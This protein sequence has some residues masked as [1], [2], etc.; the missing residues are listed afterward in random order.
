MWQVAG[1]AVQSR[2]LMGT[3]QY[4]SLEV[5][6]EALSASRTEI[7]TVALARHLSEVGEVNYF[8][9]FLQNLPY[10][11]LPNTAGCHT[12]QD[13]ITVAEMAREIFNTH[14]I[15]LEVIGDPHQLTPDLHELWIAAKYLVAQG[16]EVFPYCSDDLVY[17]RRLVDCGCNILMPGAAPI[18][19]GKGILNSYALSVLRERFPDQ[20]I[21]I[22]AGIGKP[23]DAVLAMELGMDGILLNTAIAHAQDPIK[24]AQAFQYAVRAG[25]LSSKAGIMRTRETAQASTLLLN[26][27]YWLQAEVNSCS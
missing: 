10:H 16:F 2:L 25:H 20:I 3:A 9:Q 27:P 7:I 12:A 13:A 4:P 26:T 23:S 11:I 22:D 15:K 21:I 24:M 19:T 5:M 17:C 14:W 1:K 6:S 18:G 8:W